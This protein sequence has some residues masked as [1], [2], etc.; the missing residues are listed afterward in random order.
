MYLKYYYCL[1]NDYLMYGDIFRTDLGFLRHPALKRRK[2][3]GGGGPPTPLPEG[4][5]NRVTRKRKAGIAGTRPL[6]SYRCF[7]ARC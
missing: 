4:Q 3:G 6:E 2:E 7:S 5:G 1:Q